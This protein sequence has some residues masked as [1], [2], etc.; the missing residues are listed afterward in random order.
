MAAETDDFQRTEEPTP[1]RLEE[2]RK[3]GDAP[4]SIELVA[5]VMLGA[6][7]LGLWMLAGPA[8]KGLLSAGAAFL[9]HPHEFAMDGASLTT[10][11]G[12]V[13]LKLAAI[14][15][16]IGLLFLA[17]AMIANI[18][19]AR[20][21]FSAARL[22]P[23]LAKLS[24]IA[25]LNRIFGPVALF[26]FTKGVAKI[27]IVGSILAWALWPE[28][29]VLIG[30]LQ[31]NE[32]ALLVM[33]RAEILKLLG[34]TVAAMAVIA[35][36]DYGYQRRAW[37]KRLRM[38]KDEVKRELRE[39]EGDP[40][41]RGRLRYERETR[42]RRRMLAA[43]KDATVLIMNPTHYAVALK[44]QPGETAAPICVAKG[45]DEVALRMRDV[46]NDNRVPVVLNAPLARALFA[47]AE[48]DEEIPVE[49][50]EAVANVI[51]FIMR[52]AAEAK[53]LR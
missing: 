6:G 29:D 41:I 13:S 3:R 40:L 11:F 34:L 36:L 9:D 43:V 32:N 46:A 30:L 44:Y 20:P 39:T 33:A 10:L 12:A 1:K 28:R 47:G 21:V 35:A 19:Q 15:A 24:P 45:A 26:N 42:A 18:G 2:A 31:S 48:L 52:K 50:Y 51:S 16:G 25:G 49:H 4:K 5:A 7:A 14:G 22:A 17:A 27:I 8:G 38:T 23:N 53:P 37:I